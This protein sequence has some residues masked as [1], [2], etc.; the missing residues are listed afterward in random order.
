MSDTPEQTPAEAEEPPLV[1]HLAI[2]TLV[3][4]ALFGAPSRCSL[5]IPELKKPKY[6]VLQVGIDRGEGPEDPPD[7]GRRAPSLQPQGRRPPGA[8]AD[9]DLGLRDPRP[10][11]EGARSS[12][13]RGNR[14][15][16]AWALS[17]GGPRAVLRLDRLARSA[18]NLERWVS[19][20]GPRVRQRVRGGGR[21]EPADLVVDPPSILCRAGRHAAAARDAG[22]ASLAGGG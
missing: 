8:G 7:G 18:E 10:R 5:R 9:A 21:L 22:R 13:L 16:G 12:T 6:G 11:L 4:F 19:A 15:P 20:K 1:R 17:R 2:I 14:Q 3:G